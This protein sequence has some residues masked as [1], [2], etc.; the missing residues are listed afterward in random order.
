MYYEASLAGN[1]VTC[2][3][4]YDLCNAQ[5]DL[6]HECKCLVEDDYF[7]TPEVVGGIMNHLQPGTEV[8]FMIVHIPSGK[9]IYD[10]TV[11]VQ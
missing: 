10:N 11:V 6:Y 7:G 5:K 8:D 2:G 1:C 3:H 9:A 4:S